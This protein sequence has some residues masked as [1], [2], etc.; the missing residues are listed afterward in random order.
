MVGERPMNQLIIHSHHFMG[1]LHMKHFFLNLLGGIL[2]LAWT[3]SADAAP[4]GVQL[5]PE[6]LETTARARL[7]REVRR[8]RREDPATFAAVKHIRAELPA[9]ARRQ[10][11][12]ALTVLQPLRSLGRAGLWPM[13]AELALEAEP[14]GSLSERAWHGWRVSLLE[15]VGSLREP[16]TAPVLEAILASEEPDEA[17]RRSA[18]VALGRLSTPPATAAL[19]QLVRLRQEQRWLLYL[20][21][22]GECRRTAAA[23]ELATV[24]SG[25]ANDAAATKIALDALGQ[26]GNAWA[27]KTPKVAQSGEGEI[28]RRIALE[29]LIEAYPRLDREAR[30]LAAKALLLIGHP[31]TQTA[32]KAAQSK[33]DDSQRQRLTELQQ[34]IAREGLISE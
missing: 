28:V 6:A 25:S 16:G 22:L 30:S 29:A 2:L 5:A 9:L 7:L 10:R 19:V 1:D 21:A 31:K 34:Q 27:W 24:L 20:G 32:I 4:R 14:R 17:V 12:R 26:I 18:A 11:G 8:A 23:Q 15:A 3:T 33:V 13:L